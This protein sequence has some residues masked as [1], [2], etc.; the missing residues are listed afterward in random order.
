MLLLRLISAFGVLFF[1]PY[2][3]TKQEGENRR[4]ELMVI[5]NLHIKIKLYIKIERKI[6]KQFKPK[7]VNKTQLTKQNASSRQ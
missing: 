1:V 6:C 7:L 2:T 3:Y 4:D 5:V